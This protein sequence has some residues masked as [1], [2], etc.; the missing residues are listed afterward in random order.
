MSP[1][2]D[3]TLFDGRSAQPRPARLAVHG[4][5]LLADPGDGAPQRWPLGQVRWPERTRH[6][7]RIV[8]LPDGA[9]WHAASGAA[10]DDWA[11]GLGRRDGLVVRLQRS[12]RAT[13]AAVVA[14]VVLLAAGVHWGV[15]AA[16]DAVVAMLPPS[17]DETVGERTLQAL[18][19]EWFKPSRI[20]PERQEAARRALQQALDT[21]PAAERGHRPWRVVFRA[22]DKALGPNALALPGG[23][24]IVTDALMDLLADHPDALLGV[25]GHEWGHV[26]HRHGMQGVARAALAG[27]ALS[28]L[29]GDMGSLLAA[30]PAL[31]LQM[32]YS[33]E[34]ERQA[35]EAAAAVL[36][37]AGRSPAAMVT[38]FDKL[39]TVER[40]DA[41]PF[42]SS[43]PPDE[44]RRRFFEQAAR[45]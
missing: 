23:T 17:V 3:G 22:G 40:P 19:S 42:L 30:A 36:R 20:A 44:E 25:L 18:E 6:G 31:L 1:G 29:T 32:S 4:S 15:P 12:W 21:L 41:P 2:P 11:A 13:L 26:Q 45:R 14:V 16:A 43:H 28:A 39:A 9:R 27:A 7:Q 24:L 10:F 5:D 8:E 38:F 35:D 34:F 33:R 37:A